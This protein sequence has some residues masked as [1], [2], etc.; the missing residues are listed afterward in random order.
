[1]RDLIKKDNINSVLYFNS[2]KLLA[3]AKGRGWILDVGCYRR[4]R[5]A[6]NFVENKF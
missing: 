3:F 6:T 1:M 2:E 5:E 4:S